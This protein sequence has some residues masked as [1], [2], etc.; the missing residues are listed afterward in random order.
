LNLAFTFHAEVLTSSHWNLSQAV[1]GKANKRKS[2]SAAIRPIGR[3]A[4]VARRAAR[5]VANRQ[6]PQAYPPQRESIHF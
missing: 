2:L 1:S 6:M 5:R 4:A 3:P